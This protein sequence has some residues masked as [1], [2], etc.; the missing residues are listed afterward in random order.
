MPAMTQRILAA[1]AFDEHAAHVLQTASALAEAR[2]ARLA[3]CYVAPNPYVA[4]ALLAQTPLTQP[5]VGAME[6]DARSA[7]E[8]LVAKHPGLAEAELFVE[9]GGAASEIVR[10]ADEWKADLIVTGSHAQSGLSRALIGS[11]ASSVVRYAHCPVYVVRDV[12]GSR[13]VLAATDLSEAS[14][15]AVRAA[16]AEAKRLALPLTVL[17]VH[18]P[19]WFGLEAAAAAPFGVTPAVPPADLEQQLLEGA[20]AT[21]LAVM[22]R[23]GA[24]G[25]ALVTQGA[26]ANTI[27]QHASELGAAL[28]VVGTRGRTGIARVLLGSV[29]EAV[30]SKAPCSVLAVRE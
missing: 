6:Q 20:R 28:V 16:A 14:L 19:S 24:D 13:A 9:L 7:L 30:A 1:V 4:S 17:Y 15:P 27:V 5:Q 8:K 3:V 10:R 26:A 22:Q 18:E 2:A 21:L 12:S 29:A 11:V 25:S 23:A